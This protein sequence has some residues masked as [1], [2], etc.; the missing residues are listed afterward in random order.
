MT[1]VGQ[2]LYVFGG[3]TGW[4]YNADLHR[5]DMSRWVWEVVKANNEPPDGR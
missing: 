2:Y 4:E 1:I 3:T 5:L